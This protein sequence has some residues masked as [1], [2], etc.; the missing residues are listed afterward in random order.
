M[1]RKDRGHGKANETLNEAS[2]GSVFKTRNITTASEHEKVSG[3]A[4][5]GGLEEILTDGHRRRGGKVRPPPPPAAPRSEGPVREDARGDGRAAAARDGDRGGGGAAQGDQRAEVQ[6]AHAVPS[7]PSSNRQEHRY[8]ARRT[9]GRAV[10]APSVPDRSAKLP[11]IVRFYSLKDHGYVH[12]MKFRSAVYSVRC[13]PRVVAVSWLERV[14]RL[15]LYCPDGTRKKLSE[16]QQ[17]DERRDWK[18]QL[19]QTL[20]DKYNDQHHL[21]GI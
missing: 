16:S 11:T 12:S 15:S 14:V 3:G 8:A 13:S 21:S 6:G 2:E 10:L 9:C 17:M 1:E 19:V 5:V 7:T 18:G 20:V 4:L